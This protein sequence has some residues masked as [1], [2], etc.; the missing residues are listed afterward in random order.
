MWKRRNNIKNTDI[1]GFICYLS[2]S[3]VDNLYSQITEF[4]TNRIQQ[5]KSIGYE[6]NIGVGSSALL[7]QLINATA[8]VNGKRSSQRTTEG[9][10]NH[11]Q[12]L[13]VLLNYCKKNNLIRDLNDAIV[14][15]DFKENILLYSIKSEFRCSMWDKKFL[16]DDF[17]NKENEEA[18]LHQ[19]FD[20]EELTKNRLKEVGKIVE[21][22]TDVE[23]VQLSLACSTKF[24]TDMGSSRITVGEDFSEKDLMMFCPHSG[25]YHFFEGEICP[26]FEA[27]VILNGQKDNLIYGSPLVLINRFLPELRL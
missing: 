23:N 24:F 25:N 6:G 3:K 22:N 12:K 15:N 20:T 11:I 2:H 17:V 21:L 1:L 13:G 5:Q 18:N 8:S 9:T 10:F 7:Q 27:F 19:R 14:K 16:S 26:T 4:D